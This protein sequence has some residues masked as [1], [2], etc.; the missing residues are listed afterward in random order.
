MDVGIS[1]GRGQQTS[2]VRSRQGVGVGTGRGVHG[3]V[4]ETARL[5]GVCR[6]TTRGD[7]VGSSAGMHATLHRICGA[8]VWRLQGC[9]FRMSRRHDLG[10]RGRRRKR[11]AEWVLLLH[12]GVCVV[13]EANDNNQAFARILVIRASLSGWAWQSNRVTSQAQS[14]PDPCGPSDWRADGLALAERASSSMQPMLLMKERGV[15]WHCQHV[16]YGGGGGVS[17]LRQ[18]QAAG[19]GARPAELQACKALC[20]SPVQRC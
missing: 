10:D 4:S 13:R 19:E 15:V 1:L 9:G 17:G 7:G 12:G 18:W 6:R 8:D 3:G 11:E 5:T 2:S 16:Q 20:I 14:K